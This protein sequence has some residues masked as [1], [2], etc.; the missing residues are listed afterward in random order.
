M[1]AKKIT[2]PDFYSEFSSFKGEMADFR[3]K[4]RKTLSTHTSTLL[5]IQEKLTDHTSTLLNLEEK[6]TNHT[7]SLL[8][9]ES[10]LNVYGD[11]YQMN[12]ARIER[13]ESKV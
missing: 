12:K 5:N 9:I 1:P 2:L 7:V 13:L 3:D 10:K 6:S 4:T 11:M 8:N